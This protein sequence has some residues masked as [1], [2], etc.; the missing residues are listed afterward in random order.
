[1]GQTFRSSVSR[2]SSV[3]TGVARWPQ[4]PNGK[5]YGN[6]RRRGSPMPLR[7]RI[8]RASSQVAIKRLRPFVSTRRLT[9]RARC[10]ADI[11]RRFCA[12]LCSISQIAGRNATA[13]QIGLLFACIPASRC[14]CRHASRHATSR[15]IYTALSTPFC[16]VN[17]I[18]FTI[19]PRLC[20]IFTESFV[21]ITPG[22]SYRFFQVFLSYHI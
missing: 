7:P 12:D 9:Q 2:A 17:I 16:A 18:K 8:I 5:T 15:G 13:W 1:M 19:P 14:D 21:F 20:D 6:I 11:S 3:A 4:M 10:S 22:L